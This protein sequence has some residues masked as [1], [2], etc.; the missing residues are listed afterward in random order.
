MEIEKY[1]KAQKI[2]NEISYLEESRVPL[3]K[4]SAPGCNVYIPNDEQLVREIV[5]VINNRIKQLKQE[6]SEI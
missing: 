2:L 1:N 4:V 6:F 5:N 3:R